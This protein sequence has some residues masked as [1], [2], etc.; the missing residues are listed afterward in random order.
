[1]QYLNGRRVLKLRMIETLRN[2]ERS[3]IQ[4]VPMDRVLETIANPNKK[5]MTR[6][7]PDTGLVFESKLQT[8]KLTV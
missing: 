2:N 3:L 4:A 6:H 8:A 5:L 7:I 1:M